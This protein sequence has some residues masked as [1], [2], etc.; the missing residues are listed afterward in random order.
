MRSWG[1]LATSITQRTPLTAPYCCLR[2]RVSAPTALSS[3]SPRELLLC[4]LGGSV[5]RV[6]LGAPVCRRLA[7]SLQRLRTFRCVGGHA[8]AWLPLPAFARGTRGPPLPSAACTWLSLLL[9]WRHVLLGKRKGARPFAGVQQRCQ[10]LSNGC[11][12]MKCYKNEVTTTVDRCPPPIPSPTTR[13]T[14]ILLHPLHCQRV[15]VTP[16]CSRPFLPPIPIT[17]CGLVDCR[18][19]A[20]VMRC[21]H[22]CRRRASCL[23]PPSGTPTSSP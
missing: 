2:H 16:S 23:T 15:D 6:A 19:S 7:A 4:L 13:M 10:P 1:Q 14:C 18:T 5:V 12:P 11:V 8:A 3:L 9:E 17:L 21:G 22:T 20:T